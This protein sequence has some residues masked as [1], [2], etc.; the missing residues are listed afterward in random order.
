VEVASRLKEE[1]YQAFEFADK[2]EITCGDVLIDDELDLPE[3]LPAKPKSDGIRRK[4]SY[5]KKI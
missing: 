3:K 4:S 1:L 2:K 5:T